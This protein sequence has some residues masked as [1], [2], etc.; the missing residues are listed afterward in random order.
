M[1]QAYT[2]LKISKKDWFKD[3]PKLEELDPNWNTVKTFDDTLKQPWLNEMIQAQK[4]P[5]TF[6]KLM[7]TPMDFSA[8]SMN[9]LKLNN[10]TR[11]D[12][13]GPVFNLLKGPQ[14]QKFYKAMINAVS[15]HKVKSTMRILILVSVHVEKRYGYGYL[16]EIVVRRA[17][18]KLYKF[19]EGDFLDLHLNDIE[20]ML[21]LIAQNKLFNLDGN[22]IIDFATALKMFT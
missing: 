20:D 22:V 8:F 15:K 6:D 10:I 16:N 3:S 2:D 4:P 18:Q 7:S 11:A 21:L 5:V 14:R 19:K 13:V 1:P 17:D 9:R 12:L